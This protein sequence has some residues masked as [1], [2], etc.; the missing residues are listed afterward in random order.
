MGCPVQLPEKEVALV[1]LRCIYKMLQLTVKIISLDPHQTW[2][3][4]AGVLCPLSGWG[5][6]R[7]SSC[8]SPPGGQNCPGAQ[9][10]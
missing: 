5:P 6:E 8:P 2:P 3:D 4:R 9:P 10:F 7:L 1:T